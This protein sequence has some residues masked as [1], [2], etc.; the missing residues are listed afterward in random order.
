MPPKKGKEAKDKPKDEQGA[1]GGKEKKGG[2][3]VKVCN[4]AISLY[5]GFVRL[6]L[7]SAGCLR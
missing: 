7:I 6:V 5:V 2:N 3:A 4:L 1:K